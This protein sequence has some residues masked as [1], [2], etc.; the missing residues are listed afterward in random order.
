MKKT[1]IISLLLAGV[2]LAN[3][4][5]N[6]VS[7][8]NILTTTNSGIS[9]SQSSTTSTKPPKIRPEE[10]CLQ[11]LGEHVKRDSRFGGLDLSNQYVLTRQDGFDLTVYNSIQ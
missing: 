3:S 6:I 8:Q 2:L 7:A 11:I 5:V 4:Y 1:S 9:S 10:S